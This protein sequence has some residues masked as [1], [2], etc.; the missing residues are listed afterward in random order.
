MRILVF[1]DVHGHAVGLDPIMTAISQEKPDLIVCLG[2]VAT[3][4]PEPEPVVDAL[5]TL[6]AQFIMGN[7]DLAVLNPAD[8]E[9]LSIGPVL[10]ESV[11]WARSQLNGRQ[12]AFMASF[13]MSFSLDVGSGRQVLFFHG[14]PTSA[15]KGI[16]PTSPD[17]VLARA[18][19]ATS[20]Q[21]LVGGHTHFQMLQRYADR[22]LVNPGAIG[23][24]FWRPAQAGY[25]RLL[26]W[27]EY[28][29]ITIKGSQTAV[30]LRHAAFDIDRFFDR[31]KRSGLDETLK[32]WWLRQ[33][34]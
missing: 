18:V 16:L 11:R 8:A 33:Y 14:T 19:A 20:A 9:S 29:L 25:P 27:S 1:G 21:M 24:G 10:H 5:M 32:Q 28:A 4:G 6:D 22:L 2:D 34:R 31:V 15:T 3:L 26:P 30:S 23:Q 13:P 17:E 7:H 12:L